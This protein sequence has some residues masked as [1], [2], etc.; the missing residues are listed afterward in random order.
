MPPPLSSLASGGPGQH[1]LSNQQQQQQHPLPGHPHSLNVPSGGGS[2]SGRTTEEPT[3]VRDLIYKAIEQSLQPDAALAA[4][5]FSQQHQEASRHHAAL[6]HHQ[7]QQ[8]HLVHLFPGP[9]NKQQAGP[10]AGQPG[11]HSQLVRA[12]A[13]TAHA[14]INAPWQNGKQMSKHLSANNTPPLVIAPPP[15]PLTSSLS[16][17]PEGLAM[18]GGGGVG[19][20][21]KHYPLFHPV[22][23][24]STSTT[25]SAVDDGE[26]EV[27][28][29]SAKSSKDRRQELSSTNSANNSSSRPLSRNSPSMVINREGAASVS[30]PSSQSARSSPLLS[31]RSPYPP[32][33]PLTVPPNAHQS[34]RFDRVSPAMSGQQQQHPLPPHPPSALLQHQQ[35]SEQLAYMMMTGE[36][37][38]NNGSRRPPSRSSSGYPVTSI[39]PALSDHRGFPS[40]AQASKLRIPSP[41][42]KMNNSFINQPPPPP[43]SHHHQA[44]SSKATPSLSHSPSLQAQQQYRDK[45]LAGSITQGTPVSVSN[46]MLA[47]HHAH[48]QQQQQQHHQML[49]DQAQTLNKFT[50][51]FNSATISASS[52]SGSSSAGSSSSGGAGALPQYPP[53]GMVGQPPLTATALQMEVLRH[54]AAAA[55]AAAASGNSPG[56]GGG[57]GGG[58]SITQGT[59]LGQGQGPPPSMLAARK[60]PD[61]N[62]DFNSSSSPSSAPGQTGGSGKR[63]SGDL[64]AANMRD[65]FMRQQQQQQ[66]RHLNLSSPN[67]Q[68]QQQQQQGPPLQHPQY[69]RPF[70][71]NYQP[72]SAVTPPVGM[73]PF[74]A[75][76][77]GGSSGNKQQT[78]SQLALHSNSGAGGGVNAKDQLMIDFETSQQMMASARRGNSSVLDKDGGGGL[79]PGF[80][81]RNNPLNVGVPPS[82]YTML[83]PS[84]LP[85]SLAGLGGS[86]GPPPPSAQS[87]LQWSPGLGPLAFLPRSS[88]NSNAIQAPHHQWGGGGSL[89]ATSSGGQSIPLKSSSSS[90]GGGSSR[91]KSSR[92]PTPSSSPFATLSVYQ[93]H[94]IPPPPPITALS[95]S[96]GQHDAFATLVNAA[97]Q[98]PSLTVPPTTTSSGGGAS[99]S[100]TESSDQNREGLIEKF[101]NNDGQSS[102]SSSSSTTLTSTTTTT[103]TKTNR[104]VYPP[105]EDMVDLSTGKKNGNTL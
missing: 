16:S 35:H 32:Y 98:L 71:P 42:G 21:G 90:T 27:Q 89:A 53:P 66:Q 78:P 93:H 76:N 17:K 12:A 15:M 29:L 39:S 1:N 61:F 19:G 36:M 22:R 86:R 84:Q 101:F 105:V 51:A 28:D 96:I 74:F 44:P 13:A 65:Q 63:Q 23:P 33:G 43:P 104:I 58:G 59:P 26:Y 48:H 57:G 54:M 91:G 10:M 24:S 99:K 62:V 18:F 79:P 56:A 83:N 50:S 100:Q 8:Q 87:P 103:T 41:A 9:G 68:Q 4:S 82:P 92:E 70:S 40:S 20:G 60:N 94:A 30:R 55:A 34:N 46:I 72:S 5:L 69:H 11:Q 2:G 81:L 37:A 80:L 49:K 31:V 7:Q 38:N 3:C 45:F 64:L 88:N 77:S 85:P 25:A 73:M 47:P 95:N 14:Q 67:Q 102:S 75:N 97:A 52:P 6:Q